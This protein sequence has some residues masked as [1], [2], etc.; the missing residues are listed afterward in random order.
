MNE[1]N[2]EKIENGDFYGTMTGK[3]V[4][5]RESYFASGKE[6]KSGYD[7]KESGKL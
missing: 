4:E 7:G 1:R 3:T 2:R 6:G 5:E